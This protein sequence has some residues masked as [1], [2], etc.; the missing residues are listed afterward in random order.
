MV[1]A[2]GTPGRNWAGNITY[3][4]ARLVEPRSVEELQTVVASELRLRV[5][6]SRHSFN[7]VADTDGALVSLAAMADPGTVRRLD[8]RTV[9]VPAGIRY[10]DL[11]PVLDRWGLALANL[12]SLPHIS[13]GGSVQ[14]GTHG[15]GDGIGAL[16]TQVCALELVTPSGNRMR[17]Q[18]GQPEFDGAVVALGALGVVTTLDLEVE[19]A[20]TVE[21][22]VWEG[23]RWDAVLDRLDD[24]TSAGR[25]VSLFTTWRDADAVDQVWVKSRVGESGSDVLRELGA[26][27]ADGP[28]HPLPEMDWSSCTA[29]EGVPGP[30]FDRLPHFRL[31]FT[32]SAGEELQTEYLVPRADAVAAIE[33]VRGLAHDIAPLLFVSEIRTMAGDDLWLSPAHGAPTVAIHF[34]WKPDE[35]AVRALLLRIEAALPAS[36]RPHWGK[37]FTMA[38]DVVAERYLRWQDFR[39]LRAGLDPESKLGNRFLARLG[40]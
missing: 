24:V 37:V 18:R 36:A 21:Q 26:H 12:A 14:T 15:S 6:G 10:G 28:R 33:A 11:V 40:L 19:P 27:P 4:A 30:W 38:P 2:T 5:L 16:A 1:R 9:R 13:V 34:T 25:S 22:T 8:E 23:A 39:E 20:F 3:G 17:L 7:D 35:E 29:Q 31:D 32:P